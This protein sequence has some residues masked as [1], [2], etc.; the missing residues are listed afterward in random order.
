V[1]TV[2]CYTD[3]I[4]GHL[5]HYPPDP[6]NSEIFDSGTRTWATGGSTI[7]SLTDRNTFEMGIAMLRPDGTVFATGTLGYTSIYNTHTQKWSVG[8]RL[9]TNSRGKQF[10]MEDAS[11]ALM[12]G[13]NVLFTASG[14]TLAHGHADRMHVH[15]FEFDGMG[16]IEEPSIPNRKNDFSYS[17]NLLP[18][19]NG[20]VLAVDQTNDVEIYTPDASATNPDWAPVINKVERKLTPGST[21]KIRGIRFNGMSQACAFGDEEQCATNYPL[22]RIRNLST[23]HVFYSRTH[24]HTSMAVASPDEVTTFFDVPANQEPG[25][26]KLEVV[27]NGIASKPVNV[28]VK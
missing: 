3:V 8:P 15:F 17:V 22:V 2:D 10:T 4:F 13:G 23:G 6:T 25:A 28:A 27:A 21:Y 14:G 7:N 26:S 12:P 18:L 20:S 9:P 24:D 5:K 11:A 1:L 19:P 16:Y